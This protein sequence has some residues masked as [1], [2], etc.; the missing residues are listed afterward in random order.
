MSHLSDI[1]QKQTVK[2]VEAETIY[3][4]RPWAILL[5]PQDTHDINSDKTQ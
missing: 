4:S 2:G 5:R 3:L 1:P